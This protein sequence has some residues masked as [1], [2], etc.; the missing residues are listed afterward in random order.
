MGGDVPGAASRYVIT[1]PCRKRRHGG[2]GEFHPLA[3]QVLTDDL[4]AQ[5][6]WHGMRIINKP[7]TLQA[8]NCKTSS[9]KIPEKNPTIPKI[10]KSPQNP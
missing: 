5:R 2:T 4:T 6:I 8:L 7:K 9:P 10:P 1:S 3:K